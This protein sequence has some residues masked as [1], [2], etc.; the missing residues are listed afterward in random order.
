MLLTANRFEISSKYIIET[1]QMVRNFCRT[2]YI[3]LGFKVL[4]YNTARPLIYVR[5]GMLLTLA[6][7]LPFTQS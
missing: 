6:L 3:I 7:T 5:V 1:N 4:Y 2:V